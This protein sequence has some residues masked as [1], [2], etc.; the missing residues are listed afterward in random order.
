M[1]PTGVNYGFGDAAKAV[2]AAHAPTLTA[3]STQQVVVGYQLGPFSFG[4]DS[5]IGQALGALSGDSQAVADT[6]ARLGAKPGDIGSQLD[7]GAQT[8]G[9]LAGTSL[10][11]AI[12][13]ALSVLGITAN[14]AAPAVAQGAGTLA[15]GVGNLVTQTGVASVGGAI[16]GVTSGLSASLGGALNSATG[17]DSKVLY[18]GLGLVGILLLIFLLK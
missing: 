5:P 9:A 7:A 1:P 13:P 15:G 6:N 16:G 12:K 11:I 8:V 2:Q 17:G 10:G 18:L 4:A 14:T 3:G